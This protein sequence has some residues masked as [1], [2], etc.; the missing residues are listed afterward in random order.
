MLKEADI[1]IVL[2][3]AP[4]S[5]IP[6]CTELAARAGKHII[7]GKPMAMTLEQADQMVSVVESAGVLRRIDEADYSPYEN[8]EIV[9]HGKWTSRAGTSAVEFTQEVND[10]ASGY[11]YIYHKTVRLTAER[12]ELLITHRL[13]NIGRQPIQTQPVQPQLPCVRRID[14]WPRFS[15]HCSLP[16]K[17]DSSTR[18]C[19]CGDTGQQNRVY[20]NA[21]RSRQGIHSH[22][23]IQQ[24]GG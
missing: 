4:V 14:D 11:G 9:D 13:S 21:R 7:L 16:D 23:G 20:Q 12:P 8:Y 22:R 19:A 1:D 5:E 6:E 15:D 18:F 24:P 3:A 2:I 10:P 17:D